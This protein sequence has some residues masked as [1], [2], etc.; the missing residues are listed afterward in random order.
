[1]N[2]LEYLPAYNGLIVDLDDFMFSI[3]PLGYHDGLM[4]LKK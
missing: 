2:F 4:V 3:L 1:M